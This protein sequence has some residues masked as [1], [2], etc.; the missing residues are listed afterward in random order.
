[1]V[2]N[3]PILA[4]DA[5]NQLSLFLTTLVTDSQPELAVADTDPSVD[6]YR[7]LVAKREGSKRAGL[8]RDSLA[9]R[10]KTG[11]DGSR[12]KR[13]RDNDSFVDHPLVR[14]CL[15]STNPLLSSCDL[16]AGPPV[17]NKPSLFNLPAARDANMDRSVGNQISSEYVSPGHGLSKADRANMQK[18]LRRWGMHRDTDVEKLEASLQRHFEIGLGSVVVDVSASPVPS[19]TNNPD[20]DSDDIENDWALVSAPPAILQSKDTEGTLHLEELC[21]I[22]DGSFSDE[23]CEKGSSN[24]TTKRALDSLKSLGLVEFNHSFGPNWTCRYATPDFLLSKKSEEGWCC[25]RAAHASDNMNPQECMNLIVR[26]PFLRVVM[27]L[28]A[29]YYG[30]TSESRDCKESG[31]RITSISLGTQAPF[32]PNQSFVDFFYEK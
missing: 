23:D 16:R 7:K 8:Q 28:L 13:R 26:D 1:M 5:P 31:E 27:H 15:P 9:Q 11:R 25:L 2:R 6:L 3:L 30:L 14:G 24:R 19:M 22:E 29:K 10:N 4:A 21:I 20:L 17:A 32:N 18:N 12:R